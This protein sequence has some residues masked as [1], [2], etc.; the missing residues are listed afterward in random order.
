MK[1]AITAEL[2]KKP[3]VQT[4]SLGC[5]GASVRGYGPYDDELAGIPAHIGK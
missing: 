2:P 3:M 5:H 1:H 4:A